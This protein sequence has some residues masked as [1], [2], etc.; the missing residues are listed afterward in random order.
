[1]LDGEVESEGELERDGLS[2]GEVESEGDLE[3]DGF[4]DG[5]SVGDSDGGLVLGMSDG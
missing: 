3:R 4:S 1:M 2:D 5:D